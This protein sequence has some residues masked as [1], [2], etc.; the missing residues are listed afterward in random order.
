MGTGLQGIFEQLCFFESI[1]D[2]MTDAVIVTDLDEKIIYVNNATESLFG[3]GRSE[4]IGKHPS[5][6][7]AEPERDKIQADI[8]DSVLRDEVYRNCIRNVRADG[9]F[10]WLQA[11]V[12]TLKDAKGNVIG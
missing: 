7:N 2:H 11:C 10:F 5:M 4:L 3:Y 1:L 9:T 8:L 12:V 6:F